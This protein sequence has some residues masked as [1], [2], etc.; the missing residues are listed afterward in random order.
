MSKYIRN[1]FLLLLAAATAGC[2]PAPSLQS[3]PQLRVASAETAGWVMGS[4]GARSNN[5]LKDLGS[6]YNTHAVKFRK[7]GSSTGGEIAFR[8]GLFSRTAPDFTDGPAP[9]AVFC[10]QLDE[11]TYEIYD[12]LIYRNAGE[13]GDETYTAKNPLSIKF[14]IKSGTY[15]GSLIAEAIW[16]KNFIGIPTATGAYFVVSDQ[17]VR[18]SPL[19]QARC[20]NSTDKITKAII[21]PESEGEKYFFRRLEH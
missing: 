19:A 5:S 14:E 20:N 10:Q 1:I 7:L 2:T 9:S 15:I 12:V 3:T 6:P 18:D 17:L 13:T 11:G 16:G 21:A 4:I 8:R